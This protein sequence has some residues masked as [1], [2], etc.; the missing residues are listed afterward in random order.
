MSHGMLMSRLYY[1]RI[2]PMIRRA[3][4]VETISKDGSVRLLLPAAPTGNPS[5]GGLP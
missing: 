2:G 3:G 5:P 4:R 1:D